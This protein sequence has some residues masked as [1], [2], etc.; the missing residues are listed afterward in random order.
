M[1]SKYLG[2]AISI[3]LSFTP[4]WAQAGNAVSISRNG[5]TVTADATRSTL[6]ISWGELGAILRDVRL[7]VQAD[8][9]LLPLQGWGVEETGPN[10]LY[11]RTQEP[12]TGWLFELN[13]KYLKVSSTTTQGVMTAEAP[14]SPE[15]IVARLV[16]PEG[17]PVD[18]VGTPEVAGNYG[19]KQ[20]RNQSFLP[21]RQAEVMYFA[22]GQVSSLNLHSLFDRKA[23]A[24][25]QFSDQ[26]RMRRNLQNPDLLDVTIPVPVNTVVRLFPDYYTRNLGLP[27]YVPFDD[28]YFRKA[29]VTWSSW[30]NYYDGITEQDIVRNTDWIT[31]RLKP[32]GFQYIVLDDGY[33]RGENGV[34]YWIKNWDRRKFPHGPAWLAAYIKSK[35]LIPGIWLVPNT[36]GGAAGRDPDWYLRFKNGSIVPDYHTPILDSTNPQV[37]DFLRREFTTLDDWGFKYFKFDGEFAAPAYVPNVDTSKLYDP[38]IDPLVAYRKRLDVIRE[39]IGPRRFI[40]GCPAGTPLNGIGYFDSYFNGQDMYTSWQGSYSM[41]GAI[42]ANAFLNHIVVYTMPGEGIDVSPPMSVAEASKKLPE[43]VSIARSR[44]KPLRGFGTTASEARTLVSYLALTGVVYSVTSI[45]PDLPPARV[46]LLEMTLPTLPIMPVDLFSRGSRTEW[47]LF[48]HTTAEDYI[49]N[50]P[51]ILDLKVSAPSGTYDVVGMTNW[52]GEAQARVLS[53]REQ[54]GLDPNSSYVVFDFWNQKLE[55]V[56]KNRLPVEIQP[57][58]TRVFLVHPLLA[59]PQLIGTSRH[60]TGAY[61][62]LSLAWDASQQKLSGAS[63]TVPG[64]DYTLWIYVPQGGRVWRVAAT[65]GARRQIPVGQKF[66]GDL[67]AV[68]FPGQPTPVS[69]ELSFARSEAR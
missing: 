47:N 15:R 36:Y 23:D 69:W 53:F 46:K 16:D 12:R 66:S 24:G 1:M 29:P 45:M 54:L 55:G 64:E 60:L 8:S 19:G 9:G 6:S 27:Y 48:T 13:P 26:T 51:R 14:A 3:L 25:V 40:E 59:R 20:T 32:Y 35:G 49:H 58:D 11:I 50:F 31:R 33:D 43:A 67:L 62:I 5:W 39:T 56:Y 34:H 17:V 42:S 65:T 28:S 18:W 4:A 63:Q 37:L 44:E 57:H 21:N 38:R 30:A 41:F 68:T 7:N 22:L 2:I 52:R 10:Q 61:S